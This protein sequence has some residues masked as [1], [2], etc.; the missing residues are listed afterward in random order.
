MESRQREAFTI[1]MSV[2]SA[3]LAGLVARGPLSLLMEEWRNVKT[4]RIGDRDHTNNE[5]YSTS[6]DKYHVQSVASAA[7]WFARSHKQALVADIT[8]KTFILWRR[9]V[10][11]P[12][13]GIEVMR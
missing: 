7:E 10:P 13:L 6:C 5:F 1:D 2:H 8:L 3:D 9:R 12:Q 4:C 11:I